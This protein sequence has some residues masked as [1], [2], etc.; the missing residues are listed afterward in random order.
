MLVLQWWIFSASYRSFIVVII[1]W[2]LSCLISFVSC[3][4]F[5]AWWLY[6]LLSRLLSHLSLACSL[7]CCRSSRLLVFSFLRGCFSCCSRTVPFRSFLDVVRFLCCS[8]PFFCSFFVVACSLLSFVSCR[9]FFRG[10]LSCLLS[11][12]LFVFLAW[13]LSLLLS[14]VLVVLY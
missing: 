8:R 13:F 5:I 6:V 2:S 9:S 11:S 10:G 14:S 1:E 4:S 3:R 12:F 7:S